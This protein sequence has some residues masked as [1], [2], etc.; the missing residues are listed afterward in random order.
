VA[1]AFIVLGLMVITIITVFIGST[2]HKYD[3][4]IGDISVY[5]IATPRDIADKSRN[6]LRRALVARSQVPNVMIRSEAKSDA[7]IDEIRIF[8][9]TYG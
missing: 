1:A 6:Q 4:Q 2:P 8:A 3:L 5:D 7:S 9:L